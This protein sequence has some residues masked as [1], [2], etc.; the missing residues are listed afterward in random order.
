MDFFFFGFNEFVDFLNT[1]ELKKKNF[2][3]FENSIFF[4]KFEAVTA[5]LITWINL[6]YYMDFCYI[7]KIR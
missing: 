5:S 6:K 3:N 4:F 2:Y 7:S 1:L